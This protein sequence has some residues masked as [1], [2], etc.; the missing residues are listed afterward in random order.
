MAD[1][2]QRLQGIGRYPQP[3]FLGQLPDQGL[4]HRLPRLHFTARKFQ[5]SPL[6][7]MIGPAGNQHPAPPLHDAHRDMDL[8]YGVRLIGHFRSGIRR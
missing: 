5:Q 2:N 1:A 8:P 4:L 7:G 3:G 6:V